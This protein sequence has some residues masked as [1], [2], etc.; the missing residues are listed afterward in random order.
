MH[1]GV[2]TKIYIQSNV[3]VY[4]EEIIHQE[5]IQTQQGSIR[6]RISNGDKHI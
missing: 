5:K 2:Y 1:D 4:M 3:Q 6:K